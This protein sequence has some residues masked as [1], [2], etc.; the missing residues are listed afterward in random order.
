[1]K[2]P[3]QYGLPST[4]GYFPTRQPNVSPAQ[5]VRPFFLPRAILLENAPSLPDE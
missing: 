3:L 5:S 4:R 2:M 1:M